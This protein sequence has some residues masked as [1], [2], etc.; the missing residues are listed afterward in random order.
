VL[1]VARAFATTR[2][3][4]EKAV[5]ELLPFRVIGTVLNAGTKERYGYPGY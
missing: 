2:K 4:F 5:Q 1:L 3:A